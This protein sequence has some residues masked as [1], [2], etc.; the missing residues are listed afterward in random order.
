M[1]QVFDPLFISELI[2]PILNVIF[3]RACMGNRLDYDLPNM[4]H[5]TEVKIHVF[6]DFL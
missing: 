6:D 4:A 5:N 2:F 1:D 3:E